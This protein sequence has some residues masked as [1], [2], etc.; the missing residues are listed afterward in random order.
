MLNTR[1]LISLIL[2]F[3]LTLLAGC[4]RKGIDAPSRR[5]Q[6]DPRLLKNFDVGAPWFCA[7]PVEYSDETGIVKS[8]V[9]ANGANKQT[10]LT[11][12]TQNCAASGPAP[13]VQCAAMIQGNTYRCV[14]AST[15]NPAPPTTGLWSCSLAFQVG[16][17]DD[18][19][20]EVVGKTLANDA[21]AAA[22]QECA[23]LKDAEIGGTERRD[24][25]V[26]AMMEGKMACRDANAGK[27][28]PPPAPKKRRLYRTPKS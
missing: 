6:S 2:F 3:T 16:E 4:E 8:Y 7:I 21:I 23:D 12:L 24:A 14:G 22:F 10:A 28:T 19:I 11:A 25:C 13:K 27:S 9:V 20:D 5:A 26:A 17:R 18:K 1:P 15:F